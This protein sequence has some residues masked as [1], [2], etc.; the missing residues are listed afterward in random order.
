MTDSQ[1]IILADGRTLCYSSFGSAID[2]EAPT[3]FYFHGLPGSHHEGQAIHEAAA[4]RGIRVVAISRPGFGG[5]TFKPNRT[6]LSF[7]E[8][9]LELAD[10]IH[11]RRF[12]ILGMSGGG[13]YALACLK[14]IPANRLL[15]VVAVASMY[16][17]EFGL[18][19]MM[20]SNRLIFTLAPWATYLTSHLLYWAMGGGLA[21][22]D[23]FPDV[24]AKAVKGWPREDYE[25]LMADDGK[26]LKL[27]SKS[28]QEGIRDGTYGYAWEARL[29]SSDWGFRLEELA[30][31][32]GRLVLWHGAKDI[33]I[34]VSMAQKAGALIPGAKLRVEPDD[35]HIS[36]LTDKL[37]D[38]VDTLVT[39]L[40]VE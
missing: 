38:V 10:S 12:A 24:M 22:T 6:L 25:A 11:A 29:F 40:G 28:V 5:S 21:R 39:M 36:V 9:V 1:S 32:D 33:N 2:D 34:P 7:S 18:A 37:D 31:E 17:V 8:D 15:G 30:V 23:K 20:L 3:L 19:G 16:P 35:A 27:L 26:I 14:T 13:P 4:T